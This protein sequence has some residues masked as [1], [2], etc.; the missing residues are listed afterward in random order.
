M[1][2][3]EIQ[4][5]LSY[6]DGRTIEDEKIGRVRE[7]LIAACG[8]FVVPVRRAWKYDGVQYVEILRIEIVTTNDK[9]PEKFR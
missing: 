7:D 9:V 4:L 8:S 3:Y 1:R 6:S 2:E 5:P